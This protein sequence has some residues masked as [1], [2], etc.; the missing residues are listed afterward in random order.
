MSQVKTNATE[1]SYTVQSI[2][3]YADRLGLIGEAAGGAMELFLKA[4]LPAHH[5]RPAR[6]SASSVSG[7]C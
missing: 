1:D 4:S 3:R 5:R 6:P 2:V 7:G